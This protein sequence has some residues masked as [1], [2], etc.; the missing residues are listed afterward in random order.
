MNG[1]FGP[2]ETIDTDD[3]RLLMLNH[4]CQGGSFLKPS[5]RIV[6]DINGPG[7]IASSSYMSG[8]LLAGITSPKDSGIMIG[9]GSGAGI[10]QLLYNF[11]D[12]DIICIEIDPV[13]IE[14]AFPLL[15]YYQDRGRLSIVCADASDYLK[16]HDDHYAFGCADAYTGQ[17]SLV[18]E[19]MELLADKCDNI[20]VNC[21]DRLGGKSM[22]AV[23][24]VLAKA[25]KPVK[26][27]MKSLP[28]KLFARTQFNSLANWILSTSKPSDE[29]LDTF[30]P[31][32]DLDSP[33]ADYAVD[34]WQSMLSHSIDV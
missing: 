29:A 26:L 21:I 32:A 11:K 2:I 14:V 24:N 17:Q 27:V 25:N 20:Y 12:I 8:W 4:Q 7:P 6:T 19:Y 15:E 9:L 13:M 28:P 31:F 10:V 16:Q 3:S 5:A 18:A 30:Q 33:S 22:M 1:K 23:C 34:C